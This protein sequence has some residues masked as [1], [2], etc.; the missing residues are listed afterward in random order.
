MTRPTIASLTAQIVERDAT[1]LVQGKQLEEMRLKLSVAQRNDVPPLRAQAQI[2]TRILPPHF[3][4]AR[5][6][7]M[8]MG[9]SVKVS[10]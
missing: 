5:E 7:A 9:R 1:I 2:L 8:R 6:A 10:V 3:V 4:A